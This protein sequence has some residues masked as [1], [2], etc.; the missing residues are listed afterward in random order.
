MESIPVSR[1]R[2]RNRKRK[3]HIKRKRLERDRVKV[4][5]RSAKRQKLVAGGSVYVS[6]NK[7]VRKSMEAEAFWQNYTTAQRWQQR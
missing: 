4:E 1:K 3:R 7:L 6:K 2:I 5:V